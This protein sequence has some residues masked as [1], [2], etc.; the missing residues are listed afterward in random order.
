MH[1]SAVEPTPT[2][3]ATTRIELVEGVMELVTAAV[4]GARAAETELMGAH[5]LSLSQHKILSALE[6]APDGLGPSE[7]A[8]QVGI[9]PGATSRAAEDMV[10]A[11]LLV[12]TE[13]EHDRRVRTLR[14]SKAGLEVTSPLRAVRADS[15]AQILA[16]L[17][18]DQ[19]Q[20]LLDALR[21]VLDRIAGPR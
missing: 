19:Q 8:G 18:P 7:L 2:D 10:Q 21:P 4:R 14:L 6:C 1:A 12:R 11:G 5:D 17:D 9:S 15:V 16:G 13:D 20:A 3:T